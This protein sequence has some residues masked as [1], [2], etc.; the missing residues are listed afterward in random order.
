MSG[1]R[2]PYSQAP[3]GGWIGWD[4][5]SQVKLSAR[6]LDGLLND[7][8]AERNGIVQLKTHNISK[9]QKAKVKGHEISR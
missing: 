6:S 5:E 4:L 3:P 8:M 2:Q 9:G 1:G 7:T